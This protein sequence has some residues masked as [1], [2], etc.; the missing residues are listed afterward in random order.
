MKWDLGVSWVETFGGW[1]SSA[2]GAGKDMVRCAGCKAGVSCR[3]HVVVWNGMHVQGLELHA[4]LIKCTAMRKMQRNARKIR[5]AR[6]RLA[7]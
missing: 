7:A 1:C 3:M 6:Q 2:Y 4:E 5:T